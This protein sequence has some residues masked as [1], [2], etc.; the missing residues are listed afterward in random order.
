MRLEEAIK[1]TKPF[2]SMYQRANVNLLYTSNWL[3]REMT[4]FF[5]NYGVTTKQY[6]ILRILNGAGKPVSVAYIRERLLDQL[7]DVSRIINR[8][9]KKG[10]VEKSTSMEDKRL[11]D[12]QL[13]A[14]GKQ[15]IKEANNEMQKLD[16]L[17]RELDNEEIAV[18]NNLLD[19]IRGPE[20]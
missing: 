10:L 9:E 13:K 18:L 3:N 20:T 14:A 6:N 11:V 19:K 1:Q 4:K 12:I 7:S 5:D 8:M 2:A 16:M 17:L 15:I